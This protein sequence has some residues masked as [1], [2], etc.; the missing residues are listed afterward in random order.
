MQTA[1]WCAENAEL[2]S[3]YVMLARARLRFSW[4]SQYTAISLRQ[5]QANESYILIYHRSLP[6]VMM[7]DSAMLLTYL[8]HRLTI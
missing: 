5:E 1:F 2:S 8:S 3:L 7:M 4:S 6:H